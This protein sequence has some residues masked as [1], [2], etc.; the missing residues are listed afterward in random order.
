[1]RTFFYAAS[2]FF[3]ASLLTWGGLLLWEITTLE[4][5]DSYWDRTP[6]V[7]DTFVAYW[8]LFGIATA[9][10]AVLLSRRRNLKHNRKTRPS[11]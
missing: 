10:G 11:D 8:L 5:Q 6:Q 3:A 7:A 1:M 4:S 2:G 9:I